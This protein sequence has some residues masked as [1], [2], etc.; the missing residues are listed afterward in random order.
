MAD[1]GLRLWG[2]AGNLTLDISS[3]TARLGG[4]VLMPAGE[5]TAAFQVSPGK[6]PM[7]IA[8]VGSQTNYTW[9]YSNGVFDFW[10]PEPCYIYF[11]ET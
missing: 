8:I 2:E 11:G 10:L 1:W 6:Q 5:G 9:G 7:F 3:E 4:L